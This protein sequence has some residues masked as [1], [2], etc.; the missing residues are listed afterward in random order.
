MIPIFHRLFPPA[1]SNFL[2]DHHSLTFRCVINTKLIDIRS[3][4]S[5][6]TSYFLSEKS[7]IGNYNQSLITNCEPS[8]SLITSST[9]K[10]LSIE[11]DKKES[12]KQEYSREINVAYEYFHDLFPK[13][14]LWKPRVEYP[15]WDK[16]WDERDPENNDYQEKNCK[17]YQNSVTRHIILIRHGQYHQSHDPEKR[18]LTVLGKEQAELTGARLAEMIQGTANEFGRCNL[19]VMHVSNMIRAKETADIIASHLG[20]DIIRTNPDTNLNE[21]KP[22]HHLPGS[23]VN[24]SDIKAVEF[25]R[26]RIDAAFKRY[27][28]RAVPSYY[29]SEGRETILERNE[30]PLTK[31]GEK[32]YIYNAD[33]KIIEKNRKLDINSRNLNHEFEIIVC[34]ANVIRYF[35]CRA[36][37]L[38]PEAWLRFCTFNCSLTYLTIRPSG[39]VSCRMLG[40]IGHLGY[41]KST[42]SMYHGFNW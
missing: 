38:P 23:R 36:L 26:K 39:T 11:D 18:I 31:E 6:C 41:G 10:L 27:I 4:W 22:C 14:Q 21:G 13:R 25:D 8:T 42:F 16:N 29:S 33:E 1:V 2:V 3:F 15:L 40:D 32:E 5:Y 35:L 34:H 19:R 17:L 9:G 28:Y 24:D 7:F 37:Q 30:T 20:K 12:T